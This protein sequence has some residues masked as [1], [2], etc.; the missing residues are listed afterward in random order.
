M[1]KTHYQQ[2]DSFCLLGFAGLGARLLF[3]TKVFDN[4][5]STAQKE[6]VAF[7]QKNKLPICPLIKL[8]LQGLFKNGCFIE[9]DVLA[10]MLY[11]P[12]LFPIPVPCSTFGIKNITSSSADVK[13]KNDFWFLL[14]VNPEIKISFGYDFYGLCVGEKLE[15]YYDN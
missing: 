6:N 13:N 3:S 15:D 11:L 14:N 12:Y 2:R 9:L 5:N 8:G 7:V 10:Q 1:L 4:F